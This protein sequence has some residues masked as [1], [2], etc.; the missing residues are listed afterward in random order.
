MTEHQ[1][2]GFDFSSHKSGCEDHSHENVQRAGPFGVGD[3]EAASQDYKINPAA[4]LTPPSSY[5]PAHPSPPAPQTPPRTFLE[6]TF[7]NTPLH[8]ITQATPEDYFRT[9][10]FTS[11]SIMIPICS[12]P[13]SHTLSPLTATGMVVVGTNAHHEC[14][15]KA[16]TNEV[17][18]GPSSS[19][20]D[21][22]HTSGDHFLFSFL[23]PIRMKRHAK[24]TRN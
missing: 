12:L 22:N 8:I 1:P 16:A 19:S 4:Y 5:L 6:D 17:V 21:T 10:Y 24:E 20:T 15:L 18:P 3:G 13:T 9:F 2:Q 23:Q 14:C 11:S 7:K